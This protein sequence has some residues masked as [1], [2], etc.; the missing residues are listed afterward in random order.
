M[1][2]FLFLNGQ[3]FKKNKLKKKNTNFHSKAT[4]SSFSFWKRKGGGERNED[5]CESWNIGMAL[6]KRFKRKVKET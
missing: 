1:N 2:Q 5:E 4:S 6:T 3:I